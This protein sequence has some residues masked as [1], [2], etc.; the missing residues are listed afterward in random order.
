LFVTS[1]IRVY[2]GS[3]NIVLPALGR[4]SHVSLAARALVVSVFVIVAIAEVHACTC[5]YGH[6]AACQ[7]AWRPG[8]DAV[9]LGTVNEIS[10]SQH[11]VGAPNGAMSMTNSG[12]VNEV[13]IT[14]EE[15]YLGSAKDKVLVYT[16]SG[17]GACGFNFEKSERYIVFATRSKSGDLNVTLCSGTRLARGREKDLAYLRSLPT[18]PAGGT[19]EGSLWRYT[20]DPNFRPDDRS[21]SAD[22]P[23]RS[24]MSMIPVPGATVVAKAQDGHEHTTVVDSEGNW[25]ISGLDAGTYTV[26]PKVDD[27]T[28][29]Y[30]ILRNKAEV[31]ERGCARLELRIE[32]NGRI[33]GTI[34]HG[35]PRPDWALLKIFVLRYPYRDLKDTAG[36]RTL[37]LGESKFDIG[38]LPPGQYLLGALVVAKVGTPDRYS[39]ADVAQQYYPGVLDPQQARPITVE[40]GKPVTGVIMKLTY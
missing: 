30:P 4:N 3:E 16:A 18:R 39:F 15:S 38:P 26:L 10:P 40:E 7:E 1:T 20:H 24:F 6:G 27:K 33:S 14:V 17:N 13:S 23:D 2:L 8:I 5:Q 31:A 29:V 28:Y 12:G 25:S 19:I 36:V 32:S 34:E 37:E 22:P 11:S 21:S 35:P 9:F